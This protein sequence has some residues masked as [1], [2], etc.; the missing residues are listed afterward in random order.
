M[1]FKINLSHIALII[2]IVFMTALQAFAADNINLYIISNKKFVGDRNQLLGVEREI[3]KYFAANHRNISSEEFDISQLETI[4]TKIIK[5]KNLSLV[6]SAGYYGIESINNLK[7][8]PKLAKKILTAHLSHQLLDNGILSHQ[9]IN[10]DII[11]LPSHVLDSNVKQQLTKNNRTIVL[12][13]GVSH[14]MQ[15][16]DIETDYK[17][18]KETFPAAKKYLG[19]ILAGDVPENNGKYQCYSATEAVQL[20][21]YVSELAKKED[22][23]VLVTNGPRTGKFDCKKQQERSVHG[24]NN[25]I[26]NVTAKFQEILEQNKI[27]FKLFN[28]QKGKPSSYKAIVGAILYNKNSKIIVPGES[29][30]IISETIEILPLGSIAI[31]YNSTM[32]DS[33]RKHAQSEFKNKRASIIDGAK[34]LDPSGKSELTSD[35]S[36]SKA[37]ASII[38]DL[39]TKHR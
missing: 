31:Y 12:T 21:L 35:P 14:N 39:Y 29:T 3:K 28:F 10:S 18:F 5:N 4:K 2:I 15:I 11:I 26:D 6:I 22:Y 34:R 16:A 24:E 13:T 25:T 17:K 20:A 7:S 36:A 38:Y 23:V 30:S 1:Q 33:H 8:N 19:V 37:A 9:N 32:N 27:H